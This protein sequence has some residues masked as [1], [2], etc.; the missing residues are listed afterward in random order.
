[1]NR[2][3]VRYSIEYVIEV[4]AESPDDAILKV[5]SEPDESWDK[6]TSEYD[7]EEVES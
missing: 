4:E 5:D 7:V 6:S 2:Y 1:M 3:T